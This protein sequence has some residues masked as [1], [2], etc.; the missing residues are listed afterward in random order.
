MIIGV[1][2]GT[3]G[4]KAILFDSEGKEIIRS[5]R[6]YNLIFLPEGFIELDSNQV[7]ESIK[8]C[9]KEITSNHTHDIESICFSVFGGALTAISGSDELIT[10]TIMAFDPRGKA[11]LDWL[12]LKISEDDYYRITGSTMSVSNPLV[13]I[14][15]LLKNPNYPN[16]RKARFV[17]FEE[18]I[19]LR[20]GIFPRISYSLA[21]NLGVFDSDKK[22]WS[23]KI[24]DICGLEAKNF[25]EPVGSAEVL[26]VVS[27]EV[28]DLIGLKKG[29]KIIS[30]GFDQCCAALGAGVIEKGIVANGM[31][32]VES[33]ISVLDK[34][35]PNPGFIN[36][37]FTQPCHV[38]KDKNLLLSFIFSSGSIFKWYRDVLGREEIIKSK[39]EGINFYDY[40]MERIP[41][42][43]D[44]DL[45]L[46]PHFAGSGTPYMDPYSKGLL[47]GLDLS[48]Q[49]SDI[50]RTIMEG[51]IYEVRI[52]ME[53]MESNDVK[54]NEIRSIGGASR[55]D[56]WLKLKANILGKPVCRV[57]TG[58]AGC[59]S[60]FI[61][62]AVATGLFKNVSEAINITIKKEKC[63]YPDDKCRYAEIYEEK[64]RKFKKLYP[65]LKEINEKR[66]N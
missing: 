41:K 33:F 34:I 37:K 11:E 16:I 7:I 24:L 31:G 19:Y 48:T 26:G 12:K 2:V 61:L 54:V 25:F 27:K 28:G 51:I 35:S 3:T 9:I 4:C 10:N 57:G 64:F 62:S 6:E 55:S 58:E 29:T 65:L 63:F 53:I 38:V 18:F 15:W 5:Y 32:T 52:N 23:G 1:D 13:K 60:G 36:S 45:M 50:V 30:G 44:P 56:S 47:L 17:S 14:L 8:D 42:E 39:K 20:F 21:S 66:E 46:L 59:M 40:I 49:R 22:R 43:P